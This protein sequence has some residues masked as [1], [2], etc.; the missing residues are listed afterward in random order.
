M[1]LLFKKI[2]VFAFSTKKKVRQG[3]LTH[4][5]EHR[6]LFFLDYEYYFKQKIVLHYGE[7]MNVYIFNYNYFFEIIITKNT[8]IFILSFFL[9]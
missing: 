8:I 6:Y 4:S 2:F 7:I 9:M 3:L 5:I 1:V